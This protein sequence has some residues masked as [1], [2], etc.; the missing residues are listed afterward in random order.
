M[1][2]SVKYYGEWSEASTISQ[3][4]AGPIGQGVVEWETGDR[5]EGYFHL[6]YAQINGPCYVANGKYTFA[7][8]KYVDKAWI[9]TS[10][11]PDGFGL[12]GLFEIFDSNG[13]RYSIT[14]FHHNVRHGVEYLDSGKAIEWYKG[15]QLAEYEVESFS[16]ES[17]SDNTTQL[18][19]D[20]AGGIKVTMYGGTI[21]C[22]DYGCVYDVCLEGAIEYT[23]GTTFNSIGYD[24]RGLRPYNDTY[25]KRCYPNGKVFTE[26]Y[27]GY[28]LVSQEFC[29][30]SESY[31]ILLPN[32]PYPTDPHKC[33]SARV[34]DGHILYY[35]GAT[36]D[37][38]ME[39]SAPHGKGIF[40]TNNSDDVCYEGTFSEGRCHGKIIKTSSNPADST[41]GEWER[42]KILGGRQSIT[43]RYEWRCVDSGT[44]EANG[45][46]VLNLYAKID[47]NGF[48]Y[49]YPREITDE[50]VRFSTDQELHKGG[51][52]RFENEIEREIGEVVYGA[53]YYT[54]TLHWDEA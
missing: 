17:F 27:N 10:D 21:R 44:E 33:Q 8:G 5:F 47:L 22:N 50:V 15:E 42:G 6:N 19:V 46:I 51:T 18:M 34:W 7:D 24:I 28:E 45:E 12:E 49:I 40:R 26:R 11:K 32:V 52:L 41:E 43:L 29:E 30:W 31:A 37:G 13:E 25:G 4:L 1:K 54:L 20:L 38:Q 9:R 23:D 39:D 2:Q 3:K 36:Y 53:E 48:R 14:P 16:F 35:D